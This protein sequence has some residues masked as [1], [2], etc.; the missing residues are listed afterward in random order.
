M[1]SPIKIS[2]KSEALAIASIAITILASFYFY[3]NFPPQVPIHWNI[4]GQP[5]DYSGKT[6]AAFFFPVLIIFFYLLF[7]ALPFIDPKK[8]RYQEFAHVYHLF[9]NFL[10]LFLILL[11]FLMGIA[12]LGY[13]IKMNFIV[14]WLVGLLFIV[15]GLNMG[16]IK[17]NWFIGIRTPWTLSSEE[18]W[19]K[20]HEVGGKLFAGAGLLFLIIPFLSATLIFSLIIILILIF[21]FGTLV[22]SYW[23]Y[24]Q[25]EKKKQ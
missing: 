12:G 23:L 19:R 8:D 15:F 20:T 16:Q 13:A 5:D 4:R 25:E 3:F 9:K 17:P 22:Y 24:R 2:P 21:V 14:P 7:L 1:S 18:V 11:Y 6:F 10:V